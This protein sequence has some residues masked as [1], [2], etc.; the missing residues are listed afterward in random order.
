MDSSFSTPSRR[1]KHPRPPIAL[2]APFSRLKKFS[3]KRSVCPR[4]IYIE[5]PRRGNNAWSRGS[6]SLG[7]GGC[8]WEREREGRLDARSWSHPL[9]RDIP[10]M[11]ARLKG[12][13]VRQI[14]LP[15]T[16]CRHIWF[17]SLPRVSRFFSM[18]AAQ[19]IKHGMG[20]IFVYFGI[21]PRSFIPRE[22]DYVDL[23]G[24][25]PPSFFLL[26]SFSLSSSLPYI[27][28]ASVFLVP[29]LFP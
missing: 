22:N 11:D 8:R 5:M 26:L 17:T 4:A 12:R 9:I 19:D 16:Q 21:L 29:I 1:I 27:A 13:Q 28:C 25:V 3:I 24:L 14:R 18:S 23:S 20:S 2:R 10:I 15:H 6:R 7:D